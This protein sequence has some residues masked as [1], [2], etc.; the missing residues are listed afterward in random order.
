MPEMKGA[1]RLLA[2]KY[3]EAVRVKLNQRGNLQLIDA[4]RNRRMRRKRKRKSAKQLD[5]VYLDE[6]PDYCRRDLSVG[7][8]GTQGRFCNRSS[9]G[10][11]SCE[12][13]CCGRGYNTFKEVLREKCNCQFQWCCKVVC[14]MCI[15]KVD[16]HICK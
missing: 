3:D 13:L 9:E 4:G 10:M 6:S 11:D 1:G 15:R 14:K 12:L 5:L 7:T 2:E 8:L 16:T